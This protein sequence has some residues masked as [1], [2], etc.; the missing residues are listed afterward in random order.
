MSEPLAAWAPELKVF[1]RRCVIVGVITLILLVAAGWAIGATTGYWQAMYI[2]P[3]LMF[4]YNIAVD[5]PQRWRAVRR[6][7]W[8]LRTDAVLQRSAEEEARIPLADIVDVRTRLGWSVVIFIKG[9]LRARISYVSD[10][11][12]I[13]KQIL[14]ARARLT[15]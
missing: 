14:A 9:G 7:R 6:D 12:T 5:D 13:T 10:P 4:A 3:V 8:L 2:G 1:L 11:A 15:P